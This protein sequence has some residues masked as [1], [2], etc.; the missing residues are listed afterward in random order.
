MPATSQGASM[1][2]GPVEYMVLAFPGNRFNGEVAPALRELVDSG[3]INLL[4]LAFVHKDED[5]EVT[6][7]EVEQEPDEV[8]QSFEQLTAGEG[9]I[10]SDADLREIGEGLDPDS[11]AAVV[12]WEDVW[13]ARFVEA[14]RAAGGVLVDLQRVPADV[15]EAAVEWQRKPTL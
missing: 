11:S 15:V 1:A 9:G 7:L 13:A 4:D 12:V 8:F 3:T 2:Y 10:I 6:S 14:A 5:G